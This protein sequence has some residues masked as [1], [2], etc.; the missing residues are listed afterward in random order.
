MLVDL[1]SL[2]GLLS[3]FRPCDN[4]LENSCFQI[5]EIV[6]CIW[7]NNFK[8][9][10]E[11][12][13]LRISRGLKWENNLP[14]LKVPLWSKKSLPFFLEILKVCLLNT[15]LAKIWPLIF[16]LK[17][18]TLRVNFGFHDPPLLTFKPDRLDPRQRLTSLKFQRVNAAY[19][20]CKARVWK[21]ESPKLPCCILILSRTHA[22]HS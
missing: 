14:K 6:T 8:M 13:P 7:I 22:L 17:L 16:I 5:F 1:F 3:H 4:T 12:I 10:K 2:G 9:D 18:F 19:Y 15:W 20:I 11:T 21:C